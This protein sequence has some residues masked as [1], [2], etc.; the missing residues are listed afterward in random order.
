M[1]ITAKNHSNLI[2]KVILEL[3]IAGLVG[4]ILIYSSKFAEQSLKLDNIMQVKNNEQSSIQLEN[5]IIASRKNRPVYI[6]LPGADQITALVDDYTSVDSIWAVVSKTHSISE[7]YIP[8]SLVIPDVSTRTDKSN[9]ERSVRTDIVKAIVDMFAAA[10]SDGYELMIGSGYRPAALQSIYFNSLANSVGDE[11]ANQSVARPGESEHQT[12]L[13]IDISTVSYECYLDNCFAYTSGGQW[14]AKNSYKY[15]FVLRYPE[16][17][18]DIT[19]YRYE[20]WHFRYVGIDLATALYQSNLTLDE[21]WPYLQDAQETLK[22][23]GAI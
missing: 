7:D 5:I 23:N 3:A 19:G 18:T 13:A 11:A 6:N 22:K 10:K 2:V 9:D 21:A 4:L 20:S 12:G 14:L 15:G 16:D 17:K 8:E 1:I